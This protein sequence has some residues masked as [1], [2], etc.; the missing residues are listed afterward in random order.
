MSPILQAG[1]HIA[2]ALLTFALLIVAAAVVAL[3]A[4]RTLGGGSRGKRQL[5]F[6]L[7]GFIGLMAAATYTVFRLRGQV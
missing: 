6:T 2:S 1:S 7:V 3:L 5:I 4:A